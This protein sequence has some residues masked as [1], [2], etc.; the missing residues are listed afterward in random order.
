MVES[1]IASHV[2]VGPYPLLRRK[3]RHQ[4]SFHPSPAANVLVMT[5][6]VDISR[7]RCTSEDNSLGKS[8]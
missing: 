5:P 8:L 1:D 4:R 3:D 6:L 2:P 7:V